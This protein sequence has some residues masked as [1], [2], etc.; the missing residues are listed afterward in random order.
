MYLSDLDQVKFDHLGSFD[1]ECH[2]VYCACVMQDWLVDTGA[3]VQ[4]M[5]KPSWTEM[6]S[7]TLQPTTEKVA[8]RK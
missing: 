4:V 6:G 2:T 3:D 8:L 5:T 1:V 7:P